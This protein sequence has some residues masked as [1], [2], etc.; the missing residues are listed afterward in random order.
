[1]GGDRRHQMMTFASALPRDADIAV[2][3]VAK[4]A[5]D[6]LARPSRCAIGK[7]SSFDE[8]DAEAATRCIQ[9]DPHPR[10]A[11]PD[12]QHI[13]DRCVGLGEIA[14]ATSSVEISPVE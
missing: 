7:I 14:V 9:G 8:G 2:S 11:A 4:P 1:M 6:Q 5:V 3:Q 12:H 13:A 10:D